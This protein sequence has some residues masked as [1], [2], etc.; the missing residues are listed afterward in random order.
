MSTILHDLGSHSA[1]GRIRLIE[2]SN[3]IGNRT[4]D[5]TV[6]SIVPQ[7]TTLPRAPTFYYIK[8]KFVTVL[9]NYV[10]HEGLS[11]SGYIG[12]YF[13]DLGTSWR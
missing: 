8:G 6:C 9:T 5:L 10:L 3:D 13:L 2:S 7:P 4:R 1:A 11:G 12:P